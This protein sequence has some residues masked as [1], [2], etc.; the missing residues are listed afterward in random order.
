M[1]N[2]F[3]VKVHVK[4]ARQKRPVKSVVKKCFT[5]R[6]WC[7]AY[8]QKPAA[9]IQGRPSPNGK[10]KRL[11]LIFSKIRLLPHQSRGAD[12]RKIIVVILCQG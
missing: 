6:W 9:M 7:F 2:L 11:C 8:R 5:L 4:T 12:D 1:A 3:I 10:V